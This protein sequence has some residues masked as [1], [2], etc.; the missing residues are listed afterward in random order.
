MFFYQI[1]SSVVFK[2]YDVQFQVL[3]NMLVNQSVSSYNDRQVGQADKLLLSS[4]FNP[5]QL[6]CS[7]GFM[8][9]LRYAV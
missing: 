7:Y 4:K 2:L 1:F 5:Y 9:S 8:P 6:S 3:F